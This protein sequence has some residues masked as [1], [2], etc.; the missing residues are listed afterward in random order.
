M[1]KRPPP[2]PRAPLWLALAAIACGLLALLLAG[3]STLHNYGIG[4]PPVLQCQQ[5]TAAAFVDD[6]IL[7]SD[8]THLTLLR[9]MP[10]ADPLCLPRPASTAATAASAASGARP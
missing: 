8:A 10:D 6:R 7:G 2:T 5:R 3:C 4:G 9:R 1:P